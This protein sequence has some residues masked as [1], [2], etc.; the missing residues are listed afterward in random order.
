MLH[1]VSLPE[2]AKAIKKIVEIQGNLLTLACTANI[3]DINILK[4]NFSV[5][6][7]NWLWYHKQKLL[8]LLGEF[9]DCTNLQEKIVIKDAFFHDI[10]YDAAENLNDPAF[11][12]LLQPKA[13]LPSQLAKSVGKWLESFY[14]VLSTKG[15][16]SAVT[17]YNQDISQQ[18]ILGEFDQ[19]NVDMRVCPVCDGTWMEKTSTGIVGSIDHFLPRSK[20]PALAVHPTNILPICVICNE[21]IK[22]QKDPLSDNVI[23]TLRDTVHSYYRPARD[24]LGVEISPTRKWSFVVPAGQSNVTS[25][26]MPDTVDIPARW[27]ERADELDRMVSRRI[28]DKVEIVRQLNIPIKRDTFIQILDNLSNGMKS[29]WGISPLTYPATWW[30]LWLKQNQFEALLSQYAIG[31]D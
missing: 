11:I 24:Y 10:T 19:K 16:P 5:A 15:I 12:F 14:D 22:G 8:D 4:G 23:R 29:E 7:V 17:G 25:S 1:P 26:Q 3:R 31:G 13:N 18:V 21:K 27:E 30:L 28:K 2:C 9:I 20:Y 6:T